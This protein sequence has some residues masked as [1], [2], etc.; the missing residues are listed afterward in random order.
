MIQYRENGL[1]PHDRQRIA[2]HFSRA[3]KTYDSAATLQRVVAQRVMLNLPSD[4]EMTRILD[5]G[6]GTGSQT[7]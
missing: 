6:S 1:Y 3:A 4:I 5:L 7:A 2:E